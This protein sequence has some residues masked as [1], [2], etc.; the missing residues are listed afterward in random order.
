MFITGSVAATLLTSISYDQRYLDEKTNLSPIEKVATKK[1]SLAGLTQQKSLI[2]YTTLLKTE[3]N[4]V[5]LIDSEMIKSVTHNEITEETYNLFSY[6]LKSLPPSISTKISKDNIYVS[7]YR[8]INLDFHSNKNNLFA[9][10][11]GAN[12]IGYFIEIDN[13]LSALCE[14]IK[15]EQKDPNAAIIEFFKYY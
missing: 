14:S 11:F 9:I 13:V 8:T 2:N 3:N 1:S 10:E 12:D 4:I 6:F 5:D 7:D 15:K